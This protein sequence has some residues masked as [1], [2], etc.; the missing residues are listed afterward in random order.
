MLLIAGLASL[1]GWSQIAPVP[2]DPLEP[3]TSA[4]RTPNEQERAATITLLARAMRNRS[5][6]PTYT[7]KSSFVASGPVSYT[8]GGDMEETRIGSGA[9]RWT[10]HLGEFSITRLLPGGGGMFDL[11]WQGPIP[12]RVQMVRR[13]L[14]FGIGGLATATPFRVA[15][16]TWNGTPLTCILTFGAGTTAPRRDWPESEI[17]IDS[18][19]GLLRVA[20]DAPGIYAVY[21]YSNSTEFNGGTLPGQ[22]TTSVA[23]TVVLQQSLTFKTPDPVDPALWTP[24]NE[25]FVSGANLVPPTRRVQKRSTGA[26]ASQPVIVHATLGADGQVLEAEALQVSNASLSESALDLVKNTNYG[27]AEIRG[28]TPFQRE[29]YVT[30]Q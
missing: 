6:G 19:T 16:S 30:V 28:T 24:T 18:Q 29:I 27:P 26:V 17:C 20:S 7:V 15:N 12:I 11:G 14:V 22:I 25:M 5:L 2:Y 1:A 8:G 21:D 23:G 13:T 4:P 3:V 9:R 10:G